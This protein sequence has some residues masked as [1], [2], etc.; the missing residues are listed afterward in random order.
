MAVLVNLIK[1][2]VNCKAEIAVDRYEPKLN[3]LDNFN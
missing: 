1:F 3:L 2:D